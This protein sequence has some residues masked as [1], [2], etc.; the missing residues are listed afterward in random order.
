MACRL[1]GAKD[2]EGYWNLIVRGGCAIGE[3]PPERFDRATYYDPRKGTPHRAYSLL[4]G[5]IGTSRWTTRSAP[6]R[7]DWKRRPSRGT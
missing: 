4:A 3:V 1:P 2:L 5:L 7:G 6:G